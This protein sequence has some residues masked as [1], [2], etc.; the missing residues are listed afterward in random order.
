MR[1]VDQT[2]FIILPWRL[3]QVAR[4]RRLLTFLDTVALD[5]RLDVGYLKGVILDRAVWTR[6]VEEFLIVDRPK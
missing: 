5:V 6:V 2:I 1:A 3:P 4:G